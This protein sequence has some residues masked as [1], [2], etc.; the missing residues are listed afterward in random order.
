M[1]Q[2]DNRLPLQ[3]TAAVHQPRAIGYLA[4]PARRRARHQ[5]APPIHGIGPTTRDGRHA[6]TVPDAPIGTVWRCDCGRLWV[7]AEIPPPR[8]GAGQYPA[9]PRYWTR[10]GWITRWR[11]RHAG[12]A[13]G[14]EMT[15]AGDEID[16]SENP[17]QSTITAAGARRK[18]DSR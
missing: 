3:Q 1:S 9:D 10:A 6:M 2:F 5:C 7:V 8:P 15:R 18:T 13:A 11:Y 4:P 14:P 12:P 16:A 17:S